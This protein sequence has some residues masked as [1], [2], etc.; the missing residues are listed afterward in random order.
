MIELIPSQVLQ[1]KEES[2]NNNFVINLLGIGIAT[3]GSPWAWETWEGKDTGPVNWVSIDSSGLTF[4]GPCGVFASGA[5]SKDAQLLLLELA[6]IPSSATAVWWA[7]GIAGAADGSGSSSKSIRLFRV[8][9]LTSTGVPWLD[10][11]LLEDA[12]LCNYNSQLW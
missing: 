6:G 11:K 7:W 12:V 9:G 4:E 3:W 2:L 1:R 5:K 8:S 10:A